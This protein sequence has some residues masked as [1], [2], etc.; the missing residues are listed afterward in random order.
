MTDS[1]SRWRLVRSIYHELISS[2]PGMY[3]SAGKR[4]ALVALS[5]LLLFLVIL[6]IMT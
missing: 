2:I 4:N 5:Y 6:A 3:A 1:P